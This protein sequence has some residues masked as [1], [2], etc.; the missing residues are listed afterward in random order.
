MRPLILFAVCMAAFAQ[1]QSA[2]KPATKAP[3]AAYPKEVPKGAQK[4]SDNE[5][6]WVDKDGKAWIYRKTPFSVA[7]FPEEQAASEKA[8]VRDAGAPM[9]V[10]DLGDSVEFTRKTPF[11][12]N[13]WT[14][15]KSELTDME[16][17]AWE[18]ASQ[19][20]DRP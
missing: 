9:S 1:T 6:R 14:R 11:G 16:K 2:P 13:K 15:K 19:K 18:A 12:E 3:K 5:W 17:S 7:K 20:Q 8:P 10:R 4:L